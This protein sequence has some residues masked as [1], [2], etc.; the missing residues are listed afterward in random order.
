MAQVTVESFNLLDAQWNKRK[1]RN[2]SVEIVPE[3]EMG[4]LTFDVIGKVGFGYDLHVLDETPRALERGHSMSFKQAL[5]KCASTLLTV[6]TILPSFIWPLFEQPMHEVSKYLD[7]LIA[8]RLKQTEKRH[9][10]LS[11]MMTLNEAELNENQDLGE[12]HDN[13]NVGRT[14]LSLQEIKSDALVFLCM[15]NFGVFTIG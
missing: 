5:E 15:L 8:E 13:L 1:N 2:G 9:D 4:R 7:E 12:S 3:H 14:K 10:L 11:M 6:R